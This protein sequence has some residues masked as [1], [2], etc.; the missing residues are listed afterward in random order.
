MFGHISKQVTQTLPRV[1]FQTVIGPRT[2]RGQT[3][4][5]L[6]RESRYVDPGGLFAWWWPGRIL[7]PR[8]PSHP[9]IPSQLSSVWLAQDTVPEMGSKCL[10]C[11]LIL[12]AP[13]ISLMS[14]CVGL[15]FDGRG[16][17]LSCP[18]QFDVP[19]WPFKLLQPFE[20]LRS[21]HESVVNTSRWTE[22]NKTGRHGDRALIKPCLN[23][24]NLWSATSSF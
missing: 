19:V 23:T 10:K 2:K 6:Q 15:L 11:N 9:F 18:G 16:K 12:L 13:G 8:A 3:G 5:N 17:S 14:E 7:N 4:Q 21:Q 1:V 22:P 20:Y 24:F